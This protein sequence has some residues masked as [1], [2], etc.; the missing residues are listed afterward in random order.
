ML[1]FKMYFDDYVQEWFTCILLHGN[2]ALCIDQ[3]GVRH[4]LCGGHVKSQMF[5]TMRKRMVFVET[6]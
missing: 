5:K 2:Y 6:V 4:H 3:Y 1:F